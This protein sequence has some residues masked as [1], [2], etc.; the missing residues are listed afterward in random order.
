MDRQKKQRN[1]RKKIPK[2]E[3]FTI[4]EVANNPKPF[5]RKKNSTLISSAVFVKQAV[6]EIPERSEDVMS[7]DED[8]EDWYDGDLSDSEV[9]SYG[10]LQS[11]ND[12]I[13]GQ[14]GNG[15]NQRDAEPQGR[16]HFL[17]LLLISAD[18]IHPEDVGR[19][20]AVCKD[21]FHVTNSVGFWMRRYK[22]WFREEVS[23]PGHLYPDY[24]AD[25]Q[26]GL[27]SRVI[28]ALYHLYPP[29]KDRNHIVML[30]SELESC[31][32]IGSKCL[33]SCSH[34]SVDNH[35]H[36]FIK[37]QHLP[38]A[39]EQNL[40]N[41]L[42]RSPSLW[43]N[44]NKDETILKVTCP[45]FQHFSCEKIMGLQLASMSLSVGQGM[46]YNQLKLEF[47]RNYHL[48]KRSSKENYTVVV[49]EPVICVSLLNWWH[50]SFCDAFATQPDQS[51]SL[52]DE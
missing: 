36:H 44:P 2:N 49:L 38:A 25:T 18:F 47:V 10:Q 28:S 17:Q 45:G 43:A 20:S 46:C 3:D 11:V 26:E 4:Q 37:F 8:D 40:R 15:C 31:S 23:L 48:K 39:Q 16:D 52:W 1:G 9:D 21:T 13:Y 7:M 42:I 14:N 6:D 24:I 12:Q 19:Y 33:Y 22:R 27:Q 50:P 29:F 32:L 34:G 41:S 5:H 30:D 51:E 35:F